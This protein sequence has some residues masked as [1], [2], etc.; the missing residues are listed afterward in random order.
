MPRFAG[1]FVLLLL[2]ARPVVAQQPTAQDTMSSDR[3]EVTNNQKNHHFIGSFE[4]QSKETSIFA[5]EAW[6]YSDEDKLVLVGNVTFAQGNN[7]ISAERAEINTKTRLGS[8]S[9]ASGIANVQP[10]R[11]QGRPGA[12]A[13]PPTGA[14]ETVVYFFGDSVE[15][16]GPKKYKITNGGF[17]TCVQ[18]TPRWDLHADTVILNVDHYT[19]LKQAVFTVK[20]VPL[21]YVPVLIYP[22]K[23]G[24]RATGF[25]LPTYGTSSIFGHSIHD[26]FFWAIN[27]SQDATILHDW[28]SKTGQGIGSEYRYNYGGGNDGTLNLH[29]LDQHE[30][31]Y[32]RSDGTTAPLPAS[33]SYELRGGANQV[34]P[35]NIRARANVNYFSSIES[36]Q[37]YNTDIYSSSRNVRLFGA[38]FVGAWAGYSMNGT[39]DRQESFYDLTSSVVS[40]TGPRVNI[41]RS[42]RP[43][44][45]SAVYFG[46]TSEYA[47]LLRESKSIDPDN[48]PHDL[49]AGLNRVDIWPVI[50]YPFKKWQW[51]TVNSTVSWR[52]T[53][54]TRSCP[55]TNDSSTSCSATNIADAS[56]NRQYFS[57]QSQIVGPVF[58]RIWDTPQSSYAEK[59]KHTIE[60]FLNVQETTSVDNFRQILVTDGID[61][62]TGGTNLAYGVANRFYAK[63]RITPGQPAQAREIVDVEL[64]QTYYTNQLQALFDLQYQTAQLGGGT[65]SHFS[66]VKLSVRATPT[67]DVNA[68][69]AAEFD[70]RYH[71]MRTIS[72]STTYAWTSRL[73]TN[74]GWTK[75]GCIPQLTPDC[76]NLTH[77]IN[78]STN[79]HTRDNRFGSTYQFNYDITRGS[80]LNQTI[81]GF[82]NAQCCGLAFQYQTYNYGAGSAIGA[83]ADHRFFLSFT[84]AGLGNF[85]PFNGALSG[86]PR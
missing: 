6:F 43:L 51:F 85:S 13:L 59:F 81:T 5:D 69:V 70:N 32:V 44:F 11:Q 54:Y 78:A 58:N 83:A 60:P 45:G 26:A 2:I 12:V 66:P 35:G 68:T 20:G 28:Y 48:I 25:L 62:V 84:L 67:N 34:L 47:N 65:A 17:T 86:V 52:D 19:F 22:T 55:S 56:L 33:R 40:G 39:I 53:F 4:Y 3:H 49:D 82:Y 30:S 75:Y 71:S 1:C 50:R 38:N 63:R 14:Q 37:T 61:N 79:A 21:L 77:F 31:A 10:Q 46:L 7:R 23:E 80:M 64:T 41:S 9:N 42:E 15:K 57:V 73:Q 16:I 74:V 36:S 24:D 27:R 29:F 72:A 8:F 18:P 76:S